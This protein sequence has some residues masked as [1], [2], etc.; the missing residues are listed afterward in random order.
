MRLRKRIYEILEVAAPGDVVSTVVNA[1][2]QTVIALNLVMLV[3]ETVQSVYAL[4]PHFFRA[5]DIVSIGIFSVEYILRVWS[6]VESPRYASPLRGRLRFALTPI[7]LIDLFAVLPFYLPF[8]GVDLRFFRAVRLFRMVRVAKLARYST[9]V[10]TLGRVLAAKKEELFA[11]L[12]ILLLLILFAS[13]LMYYAERE[14]QPDKF[15]SIPAAMW[16]GVITLTTVGYG[17]V[18]PAT[19]LGKILS[20]VI[21]LLSIGMLALPAAILA[22]GFV[23]EL[24]KRDKPPTVCPHCGKKVGE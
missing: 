7:A 9:A 1:F 11:A 18:V 13:A 20:S 22:S 5:F 2:I 21:A 8:M 23:E 3:V 16:W 6:C 19:L 17:D 15:S 24:R 4:V 10:R 14:A 12:F